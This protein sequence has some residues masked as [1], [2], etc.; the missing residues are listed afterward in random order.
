MVEDSS[1]A[2]AHF[3]RATKART[4]SDM[5]YMYYVVDVSLSKLLQGLYIMCI[6]TNGG[7]V[8]I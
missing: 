1:H 5:E 6:I 3:I 2:G 8:C 4:K 7:F